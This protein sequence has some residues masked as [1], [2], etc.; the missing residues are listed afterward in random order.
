MF[1]FKTN[2][3]SAKILFLALILFM[4]A[5]CGNNSEENKISPA[6][7]TY[8]TVS[9]YDSNLDLIQ[10]R[11]VANGTVIDLTAQAWYKADGDTALESYAVNESVNF[12]EMAG[13]M[14]IA[15]QSGLNG[16]RDNLSGYFILTN[17]IALTN[18]DGFDA[19]G[20]LSIGS[21]DTPF[22]GI[23]NGNGHVISGLWINRANTD[24]NNQYNG[25]FSSIVNGAVK[26]LG[27]ETS[28]EGIQ[29]YISIGIIT[30]A[31]RNSTI[32][33]SYAAGSISGFSFVGGIVGTATT[34][35]KIERS[36]SAANVYTKA[37]NAGGIAGVLQGGYSTITDSYTTGNVTA[38]TLYASTG[39]YA[40]G[41]AGNAAS[42]ALINNCYAEGNINGYQYVGGIAGNIGNTSNVTNSAAVNGLI[43]GTLSVGAIVG[44]STST[45]IKNNFALDFIDIRGSFTSGSAGILK[46]KSALQAQQT[47]SDD[48]NGDGL[49]GLGWKFGSNDTN[50]WR[51]SENGYPKLYWE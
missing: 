48:I 5:G 33:N 38:G 7:S 45:N 41:I 14:E 25:L 40:G 37:S 8:H 43:S 42:Y 20:W 24:R 26:N 21:Y 12:Y 46:V 39:L 10:T 15:N 13:V 30:G 44:E 18:G 31:M 11:S 27:V 4:L 16:I 1:I 2:T 50:P 36:Y 3:N 29:G 49:G 17:D 22:S 32:S 28:D 51:M 23:L 47:Y 9:F 6:A 19:Q 34:T 35:A